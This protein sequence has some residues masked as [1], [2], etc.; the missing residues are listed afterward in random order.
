M[1]QWSSLVGD[2]RYF[3]LAL[4][5]SIFD[6][7]QSQSNHGFLR[8]FRFVSG[9]ILRSTDLYATLDKSSISLLQIY[10]ASVFEV[11]VWEQMCL[12]KSGT[13][14]AACKVAGEVTRSQRYLDG[15]SVKWTFGWQVLI[16]RL[17]LHYNVGWVVYWLAWSPPTQ[18][19]STASLNNFLNGMNISKPPFTPAL[20]VSASSALTHLT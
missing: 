10:F 17:H 7:I 4:R 14:W 18:L 19:P 13:F 2:L 15:G 9:F 8:G 5:S 6:L 20:I 1:C 11:D 3:L 12:T 16:V